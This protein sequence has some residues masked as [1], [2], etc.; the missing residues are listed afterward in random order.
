MANEQ[1]LEEDRFMTN[2]LDLTDL[3]HD[4]AS[5]CW[6]AGKKDINPQLV[7]FAENY[8]E[9]YDRTKMIDVFI[10][11]SHMH[12][13]KIKERDEDFFIEN[14][15]LIFQNLPIDTNNINAFKLFFTA[16][17]DKGEY[18]IEQSDKDAVWDI[19]DSLVKICIKYIHRIRGVKLVPTDRGM[20]PAY[21]TNAYPKVKVRAQAKLWDVTLPIPGQD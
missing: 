18:I 2:V 17:D 19:F 15:H 6:D 21:K 16:K 11:N 14:A 12:W 1:P 9:N 4:L 10:K 7:L 13:H 8:L 5:I 20:R 3:V